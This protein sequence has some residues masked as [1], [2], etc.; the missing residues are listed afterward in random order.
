MKFTVEVTQYGM[1]LTYGKA[2]YEVDAIDEEEAI[3][4]AKMKAKKDWIV[5]YSAKVLTHSN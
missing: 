1:G 3:Y 4:L 2:T 5:P